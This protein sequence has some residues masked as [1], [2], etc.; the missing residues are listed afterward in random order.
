MDDLSWA[1][2]ISLVFVG[3]F[4]MVIGYAACYI[5]LMPNVKALRA[6]LKRRNQEHINAPRS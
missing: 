4:G 1:I 6:D 3:L 5:R 2:F